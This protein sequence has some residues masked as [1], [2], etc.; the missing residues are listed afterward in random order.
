MPTMTRWWIIFQQ[1]C[2][3]ARL[4]TILFQR[5]RVDFLEFDIYS[6]SVNDVVKKVLYQ[7]ISPRGAE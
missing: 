6:I 3:Y 7:F 2:T 1:T 5:N 4:Y